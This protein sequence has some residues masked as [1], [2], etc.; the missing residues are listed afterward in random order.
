MGKHAKKPKGKDVVCSPYSC[1]AMTYDL[2]IGKGIIGGGSLTRLLK[3]KRVA[4]EASLRQKRD[5]IMHHQQAQ[6]ETNGNGSLTLMQP[7][8]SL[9]MSRVAFRVILKSKLSLTR[10]FQTC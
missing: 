7:N 1:L 3:G 10:L 6:Q 4:L 9:T 5:A 8:S 2:L